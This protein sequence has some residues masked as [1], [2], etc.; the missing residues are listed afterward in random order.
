[1]RAMHPRYSSRGGEPRQTGPIDLQ[2]V[3]QPP[4]DRSFDVAEDGEDAAASALTRRHR[5]LA[6]SAKL[7]PR[8]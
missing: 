7:H 6:L 1:M 8:F 4:L 3:G 5:S 2:A